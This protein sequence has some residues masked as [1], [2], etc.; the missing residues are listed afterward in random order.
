MI[1]T[2]VSLLAAAP[3]INA[4]NHL[5]RNQTGPCIPGPN[6]TDA[7]HERVVLKDFRAITG[8]TITCV[9]NFSASY[10][11]ANINLESFIPLKDLNDGIAEKANDIWGWT[12]PNTGKE[13]AIIGLE[14]GTSFV[15]L[16]DPNNPVVLGLLPTRT[17]Y[18]FWRDMK[19]YGNYVFI[20]S[21]AP[22]YGMQ[23]FDLTNLDNNDGS[24]FSFYDETVHY[25]QFG[26]AHNIAINEDSGYAYIVGA[27]EGTNCNA[28]LHMVNIL[29][30]LEPTFAGCYSEQGYTHDVQCVNY[31]GPD[32]NFIGREICFASNED[33][34]DI[35]DVSNKTNS[36]LI[37]TFVYENARYVHQ[38]WL[39]EDQHYFLIDDEQNEYFRDDFTT[40]IICDVSNLENP[41][42][43][44]THVS[45]TKAIDHNLYVKGNYVYEANYR[46]GLRVLELSEVSEGR[47]IEVGYFDIFPE[48][49]ESKFNGA[50]SSYPYFKSGIIIMSGIEQGLFV[51]RVGASKN[52]PVDC[53][54]FSSFF[55]FLRDLILSR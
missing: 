22:S 31:D 45:S 3:I 44:G 17:K 6:A 11:C 42:L 25:D 43:K 5:V 34:L 7:R 8:K 4:Q 36:V 26:S 12:S 21:E 32:K 20:V 15:S 38:G 33:K 37:S 18:S 23:I 1:L 30:P 24:S 52:I 19:T 28:G 13:Y 48:N 41:T 49:D 16:E 35:V 27:Y 46:A 47:L 10:P 40:T 39:T 50:W 51:L 2:L 14:G 29:N 55:G 53:F 54:R 9:E